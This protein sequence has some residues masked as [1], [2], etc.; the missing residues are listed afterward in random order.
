M[1]P[2]L[3]E[4]LDTYKLKNNKELSQISLN[5]Y[6]DFNAIKESVLALTVTLTEIEKVYNAVY[7]ELQSRLHFETTEK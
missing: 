1:T 3:Q 6:N 4:I 5:L 7:G 2:K